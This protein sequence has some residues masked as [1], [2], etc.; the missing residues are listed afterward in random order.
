MLHS[1]RFHSKLRE[2]IPTG[3]KRA[4]HYWR[5][6]HLVSE[7]EDKIYAERERPVWAG[8]SQES[9]GSSGASENA[10]VLSERKTARCIVTRR[11]K[12]EQFVMFS[13]E[14]EFNVWLSFT[15]VYVSA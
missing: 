9:V 3:A 10:V 1:T 5:I 2:L 4:H 8:R 7:L 13:F 11:N 12:E 15:V 14:E 6:P